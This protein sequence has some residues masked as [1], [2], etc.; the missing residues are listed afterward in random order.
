MVEKG[1]RVLQIV[2]LIILSQLPLGL[3]IALSAKGVGH[4]AILVTSLSLF[5]I[6]IVSFVRLG[7][8]WQLLTL[9]I[10][11]WL[12]VRGMLISLLG[13][14]CMFLVTAFGS[15]LLSLEGISDTANQELIEGFFTELPVVIMF[16]AIVIMAPLSEEII[17]R[18]LIPDLFGAQYR[19]L[20][21]MFGTLVFAYLHNPTN[22]GSWVIYGGMG[23]VLAVVR[24]RTK[25]IE[26]SILT[27]SL[28][29][30]LAF[31]AMLFI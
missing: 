23:V 11:D 26:Y 27:H 21:H 29:N 31:I 13:L 30:L 20:G 22:L 16:L 4:T 12:S 25:H 5:V 28:N 2:G 19:L 8:R 1:L 7:R 15:F 6:V 24:Y 14:C 9:R 18:G 10:R 17:C 3:A